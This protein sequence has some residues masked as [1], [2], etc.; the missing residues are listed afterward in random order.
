MDP[1]LRISSLPKCPDVTMQIPV[2]H[3][4]LPEPKYLGDREGSALA[5]LTAHQ[6]ILLK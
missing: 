6:K 3:P 5:F 1:S 2:S 4:D